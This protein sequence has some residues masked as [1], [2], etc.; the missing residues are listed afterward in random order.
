MLNN[1]KHLFVYLELLHFICQR[2]QINYCGSYIERRFYQRTTLK[3]YQKYSQFQLFVKD[4]FSVIDYH[5]SIRFIEK[6]RK[7]T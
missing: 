6:N 4:L 2:S 1:V 5:A 3:I 7:K